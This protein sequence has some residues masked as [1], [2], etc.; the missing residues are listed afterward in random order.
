MNEAE[1]D[2]IVPHGRDPY[3]PAFFKFTENDHG[4]S[5]YLFGHVVALMFQ[6]RNVIEFGCG[7][8]ATLQAL[9]KHGCNVTGL[10]GSEDCIP[11]VMRRD[12][13]AAE[14]VQVHDMS[15]P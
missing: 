9:R 13:V 11:F 2:A 5:N 14:S 7:T 6:P 1:Y 8:G 12:P 10:D 3:G 4:W 15:Y